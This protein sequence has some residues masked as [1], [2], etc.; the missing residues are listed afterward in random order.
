MAAR[1]LQKPVYFSEYLLLRM[2]VAL[3]SIIPRAIALHLGSFA[4]LMLYKTGFYRRIAETNLAHVALWKNDEQARILRELYRNIGKYAVDFLRPTQPLP[5]HTLDN[6]DD[7]RHLFYEG[8]GTIVILGHLGNWEL[9]A[10]VFGNLIGKL[11]VVAKPM[12]NPFVESWLHS[13]RSASAVTTIYSSQALRKMLTSIKNDGVIAILIDQFMRKHGNPVPFLGKTAYT[14]S[15]VAGLAQKTGCNV[16]SISSILNQD[17]TYA[18][19]F[20]LLPDQ[21]AAR[22][23]TDEEQILMMQTLHNQMLSDQII[24]NPSHWFGW[25][26]KRFRGY[27]TYK[28]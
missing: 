13:K 6:Y 4:G 20:H 3:L 26:H 11:S 27:V 1:F 24:A 16:V 15:T 7:V 8:K 23:S 17:N 18:I 14:V 9:L 28:S 10:S 5:P 2:L 12:Q 19:K 21:P 22:T 25:F